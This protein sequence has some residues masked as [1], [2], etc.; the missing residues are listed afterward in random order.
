MP[1]GVPL[2]ESPK[3]AK[4]L[5]CR[6]ADRLKVSPDFEPSLVNYVVDSLKLIVIFP[7]LNPI[8]FL[9]KGITNSRLTDFVKM[10]RLSTALPHSNVWHIFAKA[11]E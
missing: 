6:Q 8:I 2:Y 4:T 10:S 7:K 3:V 11:N 1:V 9:I 5:G